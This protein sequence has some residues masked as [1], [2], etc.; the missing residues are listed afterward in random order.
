[1][2]EPTIR[3]V[4]GP[5]PLAEV[6]P[7]ALEALAAEKA[8]QTVKAPNPPPGIVFLLWSNKHGM[9]WK[10]DARGYTAEVAEAGRYTEDE[11][12]RYVVRSAFHGRLDQVTCMVA[13]PDNWPGLEVDH[14]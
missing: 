5:G 1:M 14:V 2:S 3:R 11:A 8:T 9:W 10:P 6:L 7:A 13:A 4:A 12:V